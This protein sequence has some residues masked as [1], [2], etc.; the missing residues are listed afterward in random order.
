MKLSLLALDVA[1]GSLVSAPLY[2]ATKLST[3]ILSRASIKELADTMGV[4]NS[5]AECVVQLESE[6]VM[7]QLEELDELYHYVDLGAL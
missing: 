7:D 4:G 6:G 3:A 5:V 1:N 2:Q